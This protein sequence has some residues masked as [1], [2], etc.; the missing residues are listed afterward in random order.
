MAAADKL[1][2]EKP[3]KVEA[4]KKETTEVE[5]LDVI[6]LVQE[7]FEANNEGENVSKKLVKQI[8]SA[9]HTILTEATF[10]NGKVRLGEFGA[11]VTVPVAGRKGVSKMGGEDKAWETKDHWTIKLR[12]FPGTS[13]EI[14]ALEAETKDYAKD[15]LKA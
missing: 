3:A 13:K 8:L 12:L 10:K 1:K 11:L 15:A 4:E 7:Q 2:K 6:A 9:Y 5:N 14:D